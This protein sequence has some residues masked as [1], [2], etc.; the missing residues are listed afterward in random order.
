MMAGHS[1]MTDS[2]SATTHGVAQ[3]GGSLTV[4]CAKRRKAW[5][6][7]SALALQRSE[8]RLAWSEKRRKQPLLLDE[9]L[10]CIR[11]G[12]NRRTWGGK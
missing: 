11:A 8:Q 4:V 10:Q 2:N 5:N 6:F 1:S 3:R 12:G 7:A 9:G